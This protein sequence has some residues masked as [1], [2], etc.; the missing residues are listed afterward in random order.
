MPSDTGL[1]ED[2]YDEPLANELSPTDGYFNQRP[3]HPQDILVPNPTQEFSEADKAR[4]ARQ[5]HQSVEPAA[6]SRSQSQLATPPTP[7]RFVSSR[8]RVDPV[9]EEDT[10]TE[11]TPLLPP[12]PPTYFAATAGSSYDLP[13]SGSQSGSGNINERQY[14]TMNRR[15]IFLPD[16]EPTDLSGGRVPLSARQPEPEWK[17]ER[18]WLLRKLKPML[19]WLL[20]I[21]AICMVMI[22]AGFVAELI[23][24]PDAAPNNPTDNSTT[25]MPGSDDSLGRPPLSCPLGI[26]RRSASFTFT[27]PSD[28]AFYEV[29]DR[30][31]HQGR[32]S[33]RNVRVSGEINIRKSTE[34]LEKNIRADIEVHYSDRALMG[35]FVFKDGTKNL[36]IYTPFDVS[37]APGISYRPCVH[38]MVDLWIHPEES[39]DTVEIASENLKVVLHESLTL[40]ANKF[41]VTTQSG[42]VTF[43]SGNTS[44]THTKV[45]SRT[46]TIKTSSGSVH[47]TYPLYDILQIHTISGSVTIEIEPKDAL[48]SDIKPAKLDLQSVSGT[49]HVNTPLLSVS[50]L[51][52]LSSSVPDRDYQTVMSSSSGGLHAKLIHGSTLTMRSSSGSVT[53]TLSPYG[54]PTHDS[55]HDI[56][57][58]SGSME[59]TVLSSLSDPGKALKNFYSTYYCGSGSMRVHF[60]GEWEGTVSGKVL[61]GSLNVNW[62][63]MRTTTTGDKYGRSGW[64]VFKGVKGNGKSTLGFEGVSGSVTLGAERGKADR[65]LPERPG[66]HKPSKPWKDALPIKRPPPP[67]V[68]NDP[69]Q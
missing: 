12:A 24:K 32:Q 49:I 38:L 31:S 40:D 16:G 52:I 68:G 41:I 34:H 69:P 42:A 6:A 22:A 27:N 18:P 33:S 46:I 37:S 26:H 63:G 60:P 56:K 4:E 5:D 2:S 61:S 14:R 57:A 44:L 36:Q 21:A 25:P 8:R 54:D 53:A 19:K 45:E 66:Y 55:H 50:D 17:R 23:F 48:K 28:F 9:F 62:P 11:T 3:N 39:F 47:G 51:A 1:Y 35:D 65:Y 15:D 10:G 13:R 20:A 29:S 67:P 43:P 58:G 64:K 7:T 59:I 30:K